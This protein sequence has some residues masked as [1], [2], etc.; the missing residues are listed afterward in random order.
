MSRFA[1]GK[2]AVAPT[3]VLSAWFTAVTVLGPMMPST[4]TATSA[5]SPFVV[6][7]ALSA[8]CSCAAGGDDVT[9]T[10][11]PSRGIPVVGS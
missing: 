10:S 6:P 2:A 5:G 1:V 11:L 7:S 8:F 3:Y 4:V 9:G